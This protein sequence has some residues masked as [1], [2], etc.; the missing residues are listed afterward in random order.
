M[1]NQV[2]L[3]SPCVA[4]GGFATSHLSGRGRLPG[5]RARWK[6]S[7]QRYDESEAVRRSAAEGRG[8]QKAG[9]EQ[10]SLTGREQ[11]GRWEEG[12]PMER[13]E[14]ACPAAAVP[15]R[16]ASSSTW[17]QM[18]ASLLETGEEGKMGGSQSIRLNHMKL[19]CWKSKMVTYW[20]FLMIQSNRY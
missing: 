7:A 20:Q 12:R 2:M 13:E 15:A 5:H 10:M 3:C 14:R 19:P 11:K 17:P 4:S 18:P 16:C 6:V 9:I 8:E 1:G